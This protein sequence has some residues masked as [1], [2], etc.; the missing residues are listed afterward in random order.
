MWNVCDL[1]AFVKWNNKA[2]SVYYKWFVNTVRLPTARPLDFVD[3]DED[4]H[5]TI[6]A[7]TQTHGTNPSLNVG[8]D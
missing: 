8:L 1:F 3:K 7:F 5:Y 6:G 2:L 4:A